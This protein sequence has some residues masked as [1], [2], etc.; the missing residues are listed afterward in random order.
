MALRGHPQE[1]LE[2]L[3]PPAAPCEVYI[4]VIVIIYIL[5]KTIPV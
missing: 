5:A 1:R 3:Q 4:C 2:R